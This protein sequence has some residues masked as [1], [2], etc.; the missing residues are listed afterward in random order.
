MPET[1]TDTVQIALVTGA[2]RG[3]GKAIAKALARSGRFVYLNFNSNQKKAAAVLEDIISNGGDG[4]LLQF[5]VRSQEASE[6]A[7]EKIIKEKGKI[8]ILVN[9]AGIRDDMLMVWMKKG[10]WQNVLDTNLTGFFNVTRLIVKNML[11]KRFGRIINISS[12]SGQIGQAGQVNYSAS[13]AGLIGATK[14]LAREIAK[15]N[16]T[17][18]AVAPGFIE[19]EMVDGLPLEELAKTIPA[20]RL[21]KPEEVAATVLFLCSKDAGYITGQVIGINGG[22]L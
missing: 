22:I 6:K 9:N 12:T 3:I 10:N 8:D 2:S 17:V 1:K 21:G 11:P 19:T 13:K 5:D 16:I 7:I 15:R 4:A 20:G 18:N 14:A